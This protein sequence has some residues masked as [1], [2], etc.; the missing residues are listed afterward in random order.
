MPVTRRVLRSPF[1]PRAGL[2]ESQ[3]HRTAA[4][5]GRPYARPG[6]SLVVLA[7][8]SSC[9]AAGQRRSFREDA[10]GDVQRCAR[11]NSFPWALLQWIGG[12]AMAEHTLRIDWSS[13]ESALVEP[14]N[15]FVVQAGPDHHVLTLGFVST[16][17]ILDDEDRRRAI[18][19]TSISPRVVARVLLTPKGISQLVDVLTKNIQIAQSHDRVQE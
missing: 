2:P 5:D 17:I 18:E 8:A 6:R 10:N 12:C 3:A 7:S 13:S 9:P 4:N 15:Q 1:R 11:C 16:P 14:V 19:M